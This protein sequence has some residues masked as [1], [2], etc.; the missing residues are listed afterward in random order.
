MSFVEKLDKEALDFFNDVA[1]RPFSQQAVA[2]LNAYWT[3]I[4][5]QAEFIFNVAWETIKMADMHAKGISL[6]HKY[7]EGNDL[8]FNIGLYFY[9]KLCKFLDEDKKKRMDRRRIQEVTA[10]NDDS[11]CP[12]E[13]AQGQS[14]RQL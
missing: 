14:R 9:E 2:F 13:G 3:E 4:G 11:Y 6:V 10:R 7:E 5:D 8:D 1:S 12:Q